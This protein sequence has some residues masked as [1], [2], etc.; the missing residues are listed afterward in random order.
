MSESNKVKSISLPMG[1]TEISPGYWASNSNNAWVGQPIESNKFLLVSWRMAGSEFCKELIRENYPETTPVNYWAKS[2]II[3]GNKVTSDL[4]ANANTKV[5]MI[6]SDPRE[7]AMNLVNFDGGVHLHNHDYPSGILNTNSV[8]FL[9]EVADKQ[10]DLVNHYT[11]K[12]GDNC[13]VLRY[14]DAFHYQT[15]FHDMVS[16]FLKTHPLKIDDV[17]KYKW[18]IYK[19]VGDFH[20]FFPDYVLDEHYNEY[21]WFYEKWDYPIEGIQLLKYNWHAKHPD[22]SKRQLTEDYTEM[23]K[24]NGIIHS[25][26]T[27]NLDEF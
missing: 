26:R 19:N 23:L 9:N 18:S 25:N 20:H 3:M 6:I 12:F 24:R 16:N 15:Q 4:I 1:W 7:I 11:K 2:H 14:E 10:I 21:K 8:E 13:I 17:R 5:F 22:V 27:K